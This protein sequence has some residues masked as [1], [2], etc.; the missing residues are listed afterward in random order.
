M[1]R[2]IRGMSMTLL[3]SVFSCGVVW[4]QTQIQGTVK[5]PS[6]AILPGVEVKATQ[7]DTGVIRETVT[8]ETPLLS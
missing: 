2:L 6:G 4:A 8:N 5:D 1:K 3:I 7:T